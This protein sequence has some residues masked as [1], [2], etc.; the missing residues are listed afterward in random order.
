MSIWWILF[1]ALNFGI[2]AIYLN[3]E[4]RRHSFP[5]WIYIAAALLFWWPVTIYPLIFHVES[6]RETEIAQRRINR[7]KIRLGWLIWASTVLM[8]ALFSFSSQTMI[9]GEAW[10]G[11]I[12]LC[13]AAVTFFL[14][15]VLLTAIDYIEKMAQ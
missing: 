9:Q 12:P 3:K 7:Y 8:Q 5:F 13:M 2:A 4:S 11:F 10:E 6:H 1:V 14:S 15:I